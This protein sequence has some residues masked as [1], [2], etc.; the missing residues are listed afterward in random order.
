MNF[1]FKSSGIKIS[2]KKFRVDNPESLLYPIGIKTPLESGD[3]R[4]EIFQV[5][6]DPLE[7]LA[8]NLRN[9]IQTNAGE[10]LGRFGLGCNLKSLLFDRNSSLKS[11][12]EKIALESIDAQVKKYIPAI[13][14]TNVT[15]EVDEKIEAY[16]TKSLAKLIITV[17][18]SV[19]NLRRNDNKIEVILY[20]GG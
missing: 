17:F 16:D 20:N 3:D 18:F 15:F 13:S 11:D 14:V 4:A 9:L 6:L 19:P 10:R 7:Q 8:D 12:Y 1:N 2:N 5:H